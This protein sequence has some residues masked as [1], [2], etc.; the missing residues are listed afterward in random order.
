MIDPPAVCLEPC[1]DLLAKLADKEDMEAIG[2]AGAKQCIEKE[3]TS[4]LQF[5]LAEQAERTF[6]R[7]NSRGAPI[8]RASMIRRRGAPAFQIDAVWNPVG[9]GRGMQS[10]N[11]PLLLPCHHTDM[12]RRVDCAMHYVIAL[13]GEDRRIEIIATKQ[14]HQGK[15]Q[16]GSEDRPRQQGKQ[17]TKGDDMG[18]LRT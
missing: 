12:A 15:P 2:E 18:Q 13:G 10:L 9:I 8:G 11:L 17:T 7:R 6:L 1:E 14:S 16:P 4:F 3:E 5:D